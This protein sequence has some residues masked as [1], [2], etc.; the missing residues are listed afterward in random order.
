MVT[1]YIATLQTNRTGDFETFWVTRPVSTDDSSTP[2]RASPVCL[3]LAWQREGPCLC[4][5]P[6]R[7]DRWV[8]NGTGRPLA[9][10]VKLLVGGAACKLAVKMDDKKKS[11]WS[12]FLLLLN[13]CELADKVTKYF[14]SSSLLHK[15]VGICMLL[16]Y[17]NFTPLYLKGNTLFC[18]IT[19][20]YNTC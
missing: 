7:A 20:Y 17:F 12:F 9:D 6:H 2:P 5:K 11:Y 10:D 8:M 3:R 16:E 19:F 14:Y 15:Y 18:A 4:S 13:Q 1:Y